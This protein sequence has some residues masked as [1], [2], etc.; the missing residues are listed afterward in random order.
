[1]LP[2]QEL[3]RRERRKRRRGII[4]V[5][6]R[7]VFRDVFRDVLRDVFRDGFKLFI[8]CP[9]LPPEKGESCASIAPV[10]PWHL[11]PGSSGGGGGGD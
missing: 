11:R 10:C 9:C 8:Y 3:M 5:V 1:M 2:L 6:F 4:K 7:Y